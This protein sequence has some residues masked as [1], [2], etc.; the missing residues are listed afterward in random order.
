MGNVVEFAPRE[1]HSTPRRTRRARITMPAGAPL[2]GLIDSWRLALESADKAPNTI[3]LY[4][5]AARRFVTFLDEQDMPGDVES[6]AAEH[7]RAFLVHERQ[8]VTAQQK[9]ENAADDH[10]RDRAGVAT[11]R[12]AHLYLGVWFNWLI[13]EGERTTVSPVL[14]ADRPNMPTKVRP[15]LSLDQVSALLDACRGADYEARR[16]SAIIRVLFDTGMRVSGL[17]GLRLDD[18]DLRERRLR[19]VLKGGAEHWSPIGAKTAQAIDRYLRVRAGHPRAAGPWLWLG[20]RGRYSKTGVQD[21][22]KLRGEQAGVDGV[23]PHRFRRSAAHELLA[24]GADSDAVRR[25]LGWRSETM[26]RYY[27]EELADERAR[28]AHARFSPGDRV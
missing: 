18:V 21:M 12:A 25:V 11:A 19:I 17:C 3:A 5:R 27:T 10:E 22:L 28:A 15:Y 23:H 4:M 13:A 20:L 1:R 16:D 8:R 7:V 9:H 2:A 24:A 14:R 6:V 26:V